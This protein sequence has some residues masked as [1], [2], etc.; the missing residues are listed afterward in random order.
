VLRLLAAMGIISDLK[1]VPESA[2]NPEG[3]IVHGS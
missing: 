3:R 1:R 2:Y